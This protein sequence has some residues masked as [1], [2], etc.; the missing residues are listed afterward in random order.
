M[1]LGVISPTDRIHQWNFSHFSWVSETLGGYL[2]YTYTLYPRNQP[3]R[4]RKGELVASGIR[5][6]W[7]GRNTVSSAPAP[8]A[9]EQ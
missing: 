7:G 6:G 5:K 4:I 3:I 2:P 8:V 1:R 9:I